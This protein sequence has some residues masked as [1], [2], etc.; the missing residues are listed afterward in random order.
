VKPARLGPVFAVLGV[1]MALLLAGPQAAV[2]EELVPCPKPPAAEEYDGEATLIQARGLRRTL[3][4]RG[5]R[6]GLVRPAN[7]FTGRPTFPL[8][9]ASINS[10]VSRVALRGGIRLRGRGGRVVVLNRL[11][12]VIGAGSA[13]FVRAR[14][15]GRQ[16]R[17]FVLRGGRLQR[18]AASGRLFLRSADARLTGA[19]SKLIRNRLGLRRLRALRTGA[20]WGRM[21]VFAQR[22]D[23]VADDPVAETP[24]EPPL[25]V[26]PVGA[27]DIV[28][29]SIKW[30]VR[31]SFIRYVN[32]GAGTSVSDG[33]TGDPPETI[34]NAAPLVYSFN[35][36]FAEGWVDSPDDSLVVRGSGKV[37][38]RYCD[39]T[40]NFTVSD[41][42]I[43]IRDDQVSRLIFR[44]NG[45]DGTAFPNSRAVMVK[46]VPSLGQKQASGNTTTYTGLPGYVPAEATGIF[47]DFYPPFPGSLEDPN[48]ELSRFGSIDLTLTTG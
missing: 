35:F 30:R 14:V 8:A 27:S 33:A 5:V 12:A 1:L 16:M 17:L 26:R 6:Q 45:T 23:K 32:V 38:F 40:I 47:A 24:V 44:V 4:A 21:D 20:V 3:S 46:L 18:N 41:P 34:G 15:G 2:A 11:E 29:A 48:A 9:G 31:E 22:N 10:K 7:Q 36:P 25:K 42:E 39:N 19:S 28:A 37:G 13:R 43:E